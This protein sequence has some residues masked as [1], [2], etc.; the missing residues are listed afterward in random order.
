MATKCL[1]TAQLIEV[2]GYG[3]QILT[4]RLLKIVGNLHSSCS[5]EEIAEGGGTEQGNYASAMA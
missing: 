2:L 5:D 1:K 4:L 3:G